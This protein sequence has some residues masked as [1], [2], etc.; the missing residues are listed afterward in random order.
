MESLLIYLVRSFLCLGALY[1]VWFL[2]MS[3][4]TF[5]AVNRYYLLSSIL[6]S[7]FLPIFD[8]SSVTSFG[9]VSTRIILDVITI[10][11]EEIQNVYSS[12]LSVFQVLAVIY[13]TG[14]VIFFIRFLIQIFQIIL[15]IRKYGISKNEGMKIVFTDSNYAPFSFF[16]L[17]FL[18]SK[19]SDEDLQKIVTH[20]KIHISQM[21][22]ID[23]I[24]LEVLTIIQWF[25]P[26]TWLYRRSVKSIHEYLAD[27]GVILKGFNKLDYQELLLSLSL[28]IQVND[29]T[30]NIHKS[31][32]K[33][34]FLMML[35]EKSNLSSSLKY[36]ILLPFALSIL[37]LFGINDLPS[38]TFSGFQKDSLHINPDKM[39]LYPGG[40]K[41]LQ[42]FI[43]SNVKYPEECRKNGIEGIVEIEFVVKKSGKIE[44]ISVLKSVNPDLDK[45][46][47][48]VVSLMPDWIPGKDKDIPVDVRLSLPFRFKLQ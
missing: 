32:I 24:L 5:F 26:F 47:I 3:K 35:Q 8:F 44:N 2:F 28:G 17:I 4:D 23:L 13:L 25:N 30:N 46:G 20:E 14:S 45:E 15:L 31:I 38:K 21:H 18:N 10:K 19:F 37:F 48:R 11:P 40:E 22:S 41:E 43:I 42:K 6:F 7:I 16:N 29:L 39:P 27:E 36:I 34:R 33:R 12:N 9:K 1:L